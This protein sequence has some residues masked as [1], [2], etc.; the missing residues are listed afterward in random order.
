MANFLVESIKFEM[1]FVFSNPKL[2]F[3]MI[4]TH[5]LV[6]AKFLHPKIIFLGKLMR[7]VYQ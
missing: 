5:K 2:D 7:I 3:Q 4:S 1:L 6:Q